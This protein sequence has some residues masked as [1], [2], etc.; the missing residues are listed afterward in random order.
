MSYLGSEIK[1]T[2]LNGVQFVVLNKDIHGFTSAVNCLN[3]LW[4]I[5][6]FSLAIS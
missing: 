3:C 2:V 4:C 5:T 1:D 6:L